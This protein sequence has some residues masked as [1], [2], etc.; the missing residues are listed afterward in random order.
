LKDS[1]GY[2]EVETP[3]G[4]GFAGWGFEPYAPKTDLLHLAMK[5]AAIIEADL[6][7]I[8]TIEIATKLPEVW[9]KTPDSVELTQT[10]EK[11]C[12]GVTVHAHLLQ[13]KS[14]T[15]SSQQFTVFLVELDSSASANVLL[16]LSWSKKPDS[17]SMIGVAGAQVFCL[18][19]ACSFVTGTSAFETNESLKRFHGPIEQAMNRTEP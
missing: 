17:H 7:R 6:Y 18:I 19:I 8:G 16:K 14:E 10:L 9:L 3:L 15:A 4:L 2:F 12:A 5:I 13:D 11:V 1:W